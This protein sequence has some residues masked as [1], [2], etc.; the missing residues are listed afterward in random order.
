MN[1]SF[2]AIFNFFNYFSGSAQAWFVFWTVR[3]LDD[4]ISFVCFSNDT[5]RFVSSFNNDGIIRWQISIIPRQSLWNV[6]RRGICKMTLIDS[7]IRFVLKIVRTFVNNSDNNTSRSV[8][9]NMFMSLRLTRDK[10]EPYE[11]CQ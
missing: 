9:K 7:P 1:F 10:N 3:P 11:N 6:M 4:T 5:V 2:K 8:I